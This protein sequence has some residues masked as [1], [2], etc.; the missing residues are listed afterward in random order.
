[1]MLTNNRKADQA[2]GTKQEPQFDFILEQVLSLDTQKKVSKFP[3]MK[4]AS[5]VTD[6][7]KSPSSSKLSCPYYKKSGHIEEKYYYKHLK[8]ASEGFRKRFKG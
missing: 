1:M 4:S 3:S 5:K 8:Q 2:R 6:V 7:R